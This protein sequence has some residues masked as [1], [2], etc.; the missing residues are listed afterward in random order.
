MNLDV[1]NHLKIIFL[2]F[3]VYKWHILPW[4][5]PNFDKITNIFGLLL[6]I[7]PKQSFLGITIPKDNF[8]THFETLKRCILSKKANLSKN[9]FYFSQIFNEVKVFEKI[10]A[11]E[12]LSAPFGTLLLLESVRDSS[13][14]SSD[15]VRQ[16]CGIWWHPNYF[17][18]YFP[19]I[20]L[21]IW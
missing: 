20:F 8:K 21:K 15:K 18:S 17:F 4:R 9:I 6:K 1:L 10:I 12:L 7:V 2:R 19:K 14:L 16:Y 13:P 11:S 3:K 5:N